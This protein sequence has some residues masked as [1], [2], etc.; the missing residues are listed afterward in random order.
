M[1]FTK[2]ITSVDLAR[3]LEGSWRAHTVSGS[4]SNLIEVTFNSGGDFLLRTRLNVRGEPGAPVTQVGRFRAEP[5]DKRQF[6]LFLTDE[7]GV[8]ISSSVRWFVD[9]DTMMS[10]I[11]RTVFRRL[12]REDP[13]ARS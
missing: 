1:L 3:R 12:S 8:P 7:F 5:M 6:R 13:V 4:A 2:S 10:D 11:G 9:P